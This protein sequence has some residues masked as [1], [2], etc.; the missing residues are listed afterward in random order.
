VNSESAQITGN[1][2]SP[3]FFRHCRCGAAAAEEIGDQIA[4]VTAGFN[5]AL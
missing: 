5:N 2:L 1:P 3:Q 4:F